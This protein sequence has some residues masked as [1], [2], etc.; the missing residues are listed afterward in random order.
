MNRLGE[1]IKKKR[2]NQKIQLNDLARRAGISPSAQD[3]KQNRFTK[4]PVNVFFISIN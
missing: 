3:D 2:E 4:Y 1:R